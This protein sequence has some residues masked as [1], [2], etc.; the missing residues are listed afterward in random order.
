MKANQER[1]NQVRILIGLTMA[2]GITLC[3]LEYG[4]PIG[5]LI[6]KGISHDH[7]RWIEEDPIQVSM[8]LPEPPKQLPKPKI[9]V[10]SASIMPSAIEIIDNTDH[11]K[12]LPVFEIDPNDVYV[13]IEFID[14]PFI[15]LVD[16]ADEMPEFPGGDEGLMRYLNEV[17]KYPSFAKENNIQGPVYVQFVVDS[18]GNIDENSIKILGSPHAVLSEEAK[19]AILKM[20]QW[21]PGRQRLHNVAVNMKLPIKFKL[22]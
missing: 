17:L 10:A 12:V 14:E 11:R 13:P 7:D 18:K 19:R 8:R 16:F 21:K 1:K 22:N 20:P 3:A 5:K 15:D 6:Y 2:L 4:K 9:K